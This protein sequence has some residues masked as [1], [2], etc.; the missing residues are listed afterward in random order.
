VSPDVE[1]E[2]QRRAERDADP[3]C[4]PTIALFGPVAPYRGGIAQYTTALREA[5]ERQTK[6][7]MISFARQYPGW[8]YPGDSDIDPCQP[9]RDPSVAYLIDNFS[10]LSWRR[11]ADAVVASGCK[12][13][14]LN[15]WT[16][17][18]QPSF[19]YMA[20]RLRKH[21]VKVVFLCHNLSDHDTTPLR[22]WISES[23]SKFADGYIV[24]NADT[25]NRLATIHPG[26]PVL[27]RQHPVYR[28]F[29]QAE[30]TLPKRGR[31]ELL[32][33]GM[34]RPYKGVDVLLEALGQL[35][36]DEVYLTI[37]GDLWGKSVDI[38]ELLEKTG[39]R[40]VELHLEYVT[41]EVAAE[42]FERADVVVLPYRSATAS[43]VAA[44]A[45]EF[46]T[47]VL[48]TSVGGLRDQV[49]DGKTGWLVEPDSP[50]AL[51]NAI[52]QLH[53]DELEETSLHIRRFT[54][55]NSWSSMAVA[56]MDL[57]RGL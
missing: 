6:V 26:V 24:H 2:T 4:P 22:R 14:I 23:C 1:P 49:V 57:V 48:A 11:A 29:P 56:I 45:Y 5:L 9:E 33:F 37:A 42:Y 50:T 52:R 55:E 3:A 12:V 47:P 25:A 41:Q 36:D 20:Q 7:T 28:H 27:T 39:A 17:Y 38:G 10:P 18:W 30:V 32:F 51:A 46:E 21:G 54:D 16:L 31:L 43:G 40:N 15:W 8:L 53:R 19:G 44:V 13:A 34:I 35:Q